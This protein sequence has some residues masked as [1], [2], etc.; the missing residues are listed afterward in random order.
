MSEN[1][2]Q[3]PSATVHCVH[4]G[5]INASRAAH[6]RVCG[7]ALDG[8][9]GQ[10]PT[11]TDAPL[12]LQST[13]ADVQVRLSLMMFLEFFIWGAWY[14]TMGTFMTERGMSA[15]IGW[16]YTLCPLAAMISPFFLGMIADRYFSSERVLAVMHLLGGL[17]M[18]A[19]PL[20]AGAGA[21]AFLGVILLHALFYMPTINLTNSI[22]FANLSNSEK[23]FPM[24]R[25]FG[26]LGWIAA[27]LTIS[28]IGADR[29]AT[30]FHVTAAA[31]LLLAGISLVLPHTPPPSKGKVATAGE[32]MGLDALGLL[33]HRSFA[34]FAISSFLIC[35]PLAAYYSFAARMVGDMGKP[36]G[37]TMTIGQGAEVAFM[38]IMPLCFARLGVKWMLAIGMFA[39]V[40]RYGLFAAAAPSG[41]MWMIV[42]GIALHGL[43]YDFF[44]VTGFIYTEKRAAKAIRAQAQGLIVLLTYG[45]GL[46][47]GAYLAG[48][49]FNN[50]V[51]AAKGPAALPLYQKFWMWPCLF[52]AG[53]LVLFTLLFRDDS[54]EPPIGPESTE[55]RGFE[56]MIQEKTPA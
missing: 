55:P 25:V 27:G 37:S 3:D 33:K 23:Q 39:W 21:M 49:L 52:A 10:R 46:G 34:V 2:L 45:L 12:P 29:S 24:I 47:I 44:F 7:K 5:N 48:E 16:A 36:V 11:P 18:L 30:Q 15:K 35:I 38:L 56:P 1:A 4:C 41:V 40:A 6:C 50:I 13:P 54:H 51:G 14:V 8:R 26:T 53:V 9:T 28:F 43:C 22:A 42:A 17:A 31:A 20:A 32:I 19:A